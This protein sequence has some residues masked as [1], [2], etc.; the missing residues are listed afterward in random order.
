MRDPSNEYLYFLKGKGL[1]NEYSDQHFLVRALEG[2]PNLLENYKKYIGDQSL[3]ALIEVNFASSFP[4]NLSLKLRNLEKIFS[5]RDLE[6]FV[7]H[8]LAAGKSNYSDEKFFEALSEVNVLNYIGMF[9][10]KIKQAIYEP[11][12]SNNKNPEARFVFDDDIIFDIEVKMPNFHNIDLSNIKIGAI[13]PNMAFTD[14]QKERIQNFCLENSVD[15]IYPRVLKLKDFITSAAGKFV[16]STSEKHFNLLFINWT[17]T[18]IPHCEVNEPY[19]I[20]ANPVNG[21]LSNNNGINLCGISEE[22]RNRISAIIVYRDT[23]DSLL[24]CDFR[25]QFLG[26]KFRYIVNDF[27]N[28][29][30]KYGLLSG[31]LGMAPCNTGITRE[32]FPYDYIYTNL[33]PP[34]LINKCQRFLEPLLLNE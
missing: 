17:Y 7:R 12:L 15:L 13:K 22:S 28:P 19:T 8:Q 16:D 1:M 18:D 26:P 14:V 3:V 21:F 27:F 5:E 24:T 33:A 23:F 6:N 32:Y 10:G 34:D 25:Y 31:A 4:S 20:L 11:N 9:C 29:R 30:L 2:D